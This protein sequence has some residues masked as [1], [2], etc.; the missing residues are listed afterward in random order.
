MICKH[1]GVIFDDIQ[2]VEDSISCSNRSACQFCVEQA[3]HENAIDILEMKRFDL[4]VEQANHAIAIERLK[5]KRCELKRIIN[6]SHSLLLRIIPPEIIARIS[7]F[8]NS[9][10]N[11]T[12]KGSLPDVLLL[13]S[14]CSDWRRTVFETPQLWS[15]IKID[16]PSINSRS[17]ATRSTLLRLATLIDEWLGR[18]GQLPLNIS[19][20]S[21][22]EISKSSWTFEEYRPIFKILNKYSSRWHSLDIFIPQDLL[23]FL[24]PDCLPLLEHLHITSSAIYS[25]LII[26]YDEP[27][28]D[29]VVTFPPAP[30]LN[31]VEIQPF[32]NSG[33]KM[34]ASPH[35]QVGIHWDTVTHVSLQS[36]TTGDCFALLRLNPQLIH[37]TFHKVVDDVDHRLLESP[38][39]SHLTY[40]SLHHQFNHPCRVLDFIKLPCLETLVLFN[41]TIDPVIA[42]IERSACSLHT[43][44]LLNWQ[45]RKTDILLPLLQFLSPSLT[46]LAISRLPSPMRG[47]R[48]YLSL[49][50][51]IYTSQSEVVGNDFLPHLEIFEYREESPSTLES[52][53]LSNLPSRNYS[54]PTTSISLRSA[55]ISKASIIN[56]HLPRDISPILRRLQEDGILAYT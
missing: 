12:I 2:G 44:S 43:L 14:V 52:S 55:Y 23:S 34:L 15:S 13:S 47:T 41:V 32:T 49:L 56:K 1:C 46:R 18:S 37:C 29:H 9:N 27:Q 8:A 10:F 31:T 4:L 6:R 11:F 42:L 21:G 50:I 38:T 16:L 33:N 48:N 19:L 39:L 26:I 25:R 30:C 3:N 28:P 40:L 36:I 5:I 7:E 53:I 24:Q 22:H 35:I 54:K 51:R 45:N 17:I 20:H